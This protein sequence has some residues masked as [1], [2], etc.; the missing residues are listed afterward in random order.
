MDDFML[1]GVY[2]IAPTPFEED[3][4]LDVPSLS[5][6]T[7]F[8]VELGIVTTR[9]HPA[10]SIFATTSPNYAPPKNGPKN[11][12]KVPPRGAYRGACVR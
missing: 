8:L 6:L 3:G 9:S 4:S 2:T 5:M 12:K 10:C 1:K 11:T 7:R